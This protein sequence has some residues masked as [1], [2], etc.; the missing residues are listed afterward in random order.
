M[1]SEFTIGNSKISSGP[2]VRQPTC[3][4]LRAGMFGGPWR[5]CNWQKNRE[6]HG[7]TSVELSEAA[8]RQTASYEN[9]RRHFARVANRAP[10]RAGLDVDHDLPGMFGPSKQETGAV[11]QRQAD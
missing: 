10:G 1:P 2:V 3:S 11:P 7:P 6:T 5:L 4:T 8:S 9:P